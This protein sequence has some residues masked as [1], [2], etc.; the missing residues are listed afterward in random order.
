MVSRKEVKRLIDG[1]VMSHDIEHKSICESVSFFSFLYSHKDYR[2]R[3][4]PV[5]PKYFA[6]IRF[7]L[8]DVRFFHIC[9]D[10]D[11]IHTDG[12]AKFVSPKIVLD[13]RTMLVKF[14]DEFMFEAEEK[15][16]FE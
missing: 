16:I 4:Y 2:D 3:L 12:L 5:S 10:D 1:I 8:I 15:E 11:D 13:N 14:F 6:D 9:M 7:E